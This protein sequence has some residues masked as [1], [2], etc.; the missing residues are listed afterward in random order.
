[1]KT[2]NYKNDYQYSPKAC[3]E[4]AQFRM[5]RD[6]QFGKTQVKKN[7]CGMHAMFVMTNFVMG[8]TGDQISYVKIAD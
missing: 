2:C 6:R 4:P 5:E 7:L 1:M 8:N 3:G